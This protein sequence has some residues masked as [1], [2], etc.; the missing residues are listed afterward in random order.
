MVVLFSQLVVDMIN[1][2]MMYSDID[3]NKSREIFFEGLDIVQKAWNSKD[4]MFLMMVKTFHFEEIQLTPR[5]V[6]EQLTNLC[7]SIQ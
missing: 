4:G 5:P 6:Q 3:F 1:V 7:C 2:N